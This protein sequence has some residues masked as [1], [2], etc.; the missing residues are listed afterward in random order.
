MYSLTKVHELA[1]DM[2]VADGSVQ[3]FG[4][5]PYAMQ[6]LKVWIR[7]TVDFAKV[8]G[9]SPKRS[10]ST[11]MLLL[12]AECLLVPVIIATVSCELTDNFRARC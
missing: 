7:M 9:L 4:P 3:S 6:I 5:L 11:A 12:I 10:Q 1:V 8:M 2:Q